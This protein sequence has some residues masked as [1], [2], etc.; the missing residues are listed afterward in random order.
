[1]ELINDTTFPLPHYELSPQRDSLRN[2]T[3]SV[4]LQPLE[5]HNQNRAFYPVP[6]GY[7]A[8]SAE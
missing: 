7:R 6:I 1:M 3:G 4:T 8:Q 2:L 5:S